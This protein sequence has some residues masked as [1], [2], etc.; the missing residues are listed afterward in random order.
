[1]PIARSS[2]SILAMLSLALSPVL[3]QVVAGPPRDAAAANQPTERRIPIGSSTISG[4][5]VTAD[6]GRP[7]RGARVNVSGQV[8]AN[9]EAMNA[10]G[11]ATSGPAPGVVPM[12]ITGGRGGVATQLTGG[13]GTPTGMS[14]S[15]MTDANGQFSF[16]R[17]PAGQFQ[18]TV[19]HTQFLPLNFGQRRPGGQPSYLRLADGQQLTLKLPM[20][21]GAVITGTVLGP[22]G[23]PQ[24]HAQIRAWRY[25][26]NGGFRRL[27]TS[28]YASADDRGVYRMFGLQPGSY[29]VSATP[30]ASQAMSDER[31]NAQNDLVEQAIAAGKAIPPAAPGMTPTVSVPVMP[32]PVPGTTTAPPAY[33]QTFAPNALTPSDATTVTVA[34]GEE[35]PGVD[36][37]VRLVQAT[38]VQGEVPPSSEPGV[39]V[40]VVLINEDPSIDAIEGTTTRADRNGKFMFRALKPGKYS[41]L[42]QTVPEPPQM[43]I[44]NGQPTPPAQPPVLT[45]EQKKWGKTRFAVEGEPV[46]NVT[47][48]LR[49]TRTIS[50]VVVFDMARPPDLSRQRVTV[51]ASLAPAAQQSFYRAQPPVPVGP[52]GRFTLTGLIPGRFI[53]RASGGGLLKSSMIGGQDTLDFP[54]EFEGDR[55][56][57]DAVLTLTDKSSELS[58]VLTD[59]SGKPTSD[60]MIVAAASD[61]RYWVP[62]SRRISVTR[63]GPDGRYTF[64][65]LPPGSY[66]M[67][68][69]IDPE[70]GAQYDPEFLKS[71]GAA[72][73]TVTVLEGAK[74]T[75][76]LRVK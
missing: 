43:T 18:I 2:A 17:M 74:V 11:R 28:G 67:A 23:E 29:L 21:R 3:A 19:Q 58:G 60:Y 30:N 35:H 49:P 48:A 10:T 73:V 66:V 32:P 61:S 64:R 33:L 57:T 59:S 68:A 8:T 13:M 54:L 69:V 52:D 42:A 71:L 50:G 62:G 6:T 1:M 53:V 16:P 34:G 76:D 26:M 56:I 31:F 15:V 27:Q 12:I 51:S 40:Q 65:S 25:T 46:V 36:V 14:R 45:D 7:I 39:A 38:N 5:V 9:L 24:P 55:D 75:Q 41:V 70:P 4:S 47:I 20:Q 37:F 44:V 72:G 22:D 63:P